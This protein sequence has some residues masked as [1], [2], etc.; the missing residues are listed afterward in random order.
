MKDKFKKKISVFIEIL[1]LPVAVH[2]SE[3]LF[4]CFSGSG[5]GFEMVEGLGNDVEFRDFE[6][7][8]DNEGF[9]EG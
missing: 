2:N 5:V 3:G 9:H 8:A 1:G 7:T 4:E 6:I